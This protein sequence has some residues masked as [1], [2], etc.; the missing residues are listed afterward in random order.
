[1]EDVLE[2]FNWETAVVYLDDAIV[3]SS[4][5]EEHL[6]LLR[7]ILDRFRQAGLKLHP[8]KCQVA[9]RKVNFL[10]H[11][12]DETGIRPTED[13]VEAVKHWPQ[14][15]NVHEVRRYLGMVGYYRQ[16]IPHFSDKSVHLTNLLQKESPWE[17]STECEREFQNLKKDLQWYPV[18]QS[19]DPA[20]RFVL[21]TDA[22]STGW[23]A[24][25]SQAS[26]VVAFASGKWTSAEK[27]WSVTE[28]ELGA[29]VK[30][31]LK[32]HH[33]LVGQPFL[34]R[35][36]HEAI[37]FM[38]CSKCPSGRLFRWIEH[39]QQYDY[40]VEHVPGHQIPHVD[41]LSRQF[42]RD[43]GKH[44][45]RPTAPEFVP[46]GDISKTP[47]GDSFKTAEHDILTPESSMWSTPVSGIYMASETGITRTPESGFSRMTRSNVSR[48]P[49]GGKSRTSEV[50]LRRS[51][52]ED[53]QTARP[54]D[55]S[56]GTA[57]DPVDIKMLGDLVAATRTDPV[58]HQLILHMKN[59]EMKTD[60]LTDKEKSELTFYIRLPGL[61]LQDGI[62]LRSSRGHQRPQV[63][64]P[65]SLRLHALQLAHDSP[66]AGHG[67]V[68]R[69]LHRMT[70]GF[71]WYNLQRD[72]R[73][74]CRSCTSCRKMKP[75]YMGSME[76]RG[77]ISVEG[78]PFLHWSADILELPESDSG[79]RYVLVVTDLFSKW[80]ETFPLVRQTAEEVA[81]CLV[82]VMCRFG[83][84]KSLLTDQGR[85]FECTLIRGLCQML[86]VKKLR[87]T[88]YHPCC[89]GQVERVNR[90]LLELLTHYVSENQRDWDRWLSVITSAYNS[91][92]HSVTGF[93]PCE[94]VY[95]KP[96]RTVLEDQFSAESMKNQS[97]RQFLTKLRTRLKDAHQQA[98]EQ[99]QQ[100]QSLRTETRPAT[101]QPGDTVWC[102]NFTAGKGVHA[103]LKPKFEGPYIVM[104]ARPPDYVLKKGRKRLR[105]FPPAATSVLIGCFPVVNS[106][107]PAAT[108]TCSCGSG[109][110]TATSSAVAS[111]DVWAPV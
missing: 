31:T 109:G 45:L 39:L 111:L 101:F 3:Y 70:A 89:N 46:R 1:M 32:F 75:K 81:V 13:K 83:I 93:S 6:T 105:P 37:K 5:M 87:T 66:M 68:R 86:G 110:P 22:S 90:S 92:R 33:Y 73:R 58:L 12:L 7:Q 55:N 24:E 48:N 34:L 98:L 63:I 61:R 9:V 64:L 4:S 44:Q 14:P 82:Q 69:T 29:V 85:N 56:K 26:G 103:K 53:Q 18:L 78:E 16:Y 10:G 59:K 65:T 51:T 76:G 54:D 20:E 50:C 88:I 57:E 21:T 42:E 95:G 84:M 97:H 104:E 106:S 36:D 23:G 11:Q 100:Q 91:S 74:Y 60:Q 94:L 108:E 67:G 96:M 79:K 72:V 80:I 47:E 71:F 28:R 43:A 35:T 40:T 49:E 2:G 107:P 30:A 8:D 25:L 77:T 17:W 27:N 19:P 38:Q 52:V 99:I 62:L 41:A 15:S 102:R